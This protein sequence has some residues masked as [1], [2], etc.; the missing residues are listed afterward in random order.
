MGQESE[1]RLAGSSAQGLGA[2]V[3]VLIGLLRV[4]R[5]AVKVLI[6]A[7]LLSKAW[8]SSK[9]MCFLAEFISSQ[10]QNLWQLASLRPSGERLFD[11][12]SL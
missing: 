5:P 11:A 9:F 6:G 4:S 7:A 2:T 10:P 12:S 1:Q 3:K 8:P